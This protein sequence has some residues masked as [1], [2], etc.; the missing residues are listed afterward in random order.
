[1]VI[2]RSCGADSIP[3]ATKELIL[4]AARKLNYGR[5]F[6][7]RFLRRRRSFT[8]GVIVPEVSEA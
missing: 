7:A 3:Q 5:N 4:A 1:V 2:H 8:A 6:V